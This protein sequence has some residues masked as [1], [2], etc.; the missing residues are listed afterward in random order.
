MMATCYQAGIDKGEIELIKL[1]KY[2]LFEAFYRL[3]GAFPFKGRF[4]RLK[5]ALPF[6]TID[7]DR[8]KAA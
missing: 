7:F 8:S 3:K 4:F 6:R 2:I 1:I 5:G